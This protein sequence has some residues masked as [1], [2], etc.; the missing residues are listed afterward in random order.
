[1]RGTKHLSDMGFMSPQMTSLEK[2]Q[3]VIGWR[4]FMKGKISREFLDI[5]N[6][7][8]GLGCHRING[9]KCVSQFISKILHITHN[10]WIFRNFTLRDKQKE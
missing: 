10:Q 2:R 4:N 5:Q 8:L 1:M 6:L 9:K 7:H 3:G